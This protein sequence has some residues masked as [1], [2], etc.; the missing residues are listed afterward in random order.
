[1]LHLLTAKTCFPGYV[2][3]PS[4]EFLVRNCRHRPTGRQACS[5]AQFLSL[6]RNIWVSCSRYY[7]KRLPLKWCLLDFWGQRTNWGQVPPGSPCLSAG[8]GLRLPHFAIPDAN[9]FLIKGQY[10]NAYH[11][12]VAQTCEAI[13]RI[14]FRRSPRETSTL[15]INAERWNSHCN[16]QLKRVTFQCPP[17]TYRVDKKVSL[18]IIAITLCAVNQL[19]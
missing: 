12:H 9:K 13:I 6:Q 16:D 19:S 10:T 14:F 4:N 15:F 5:Q 1:V 8:K 11:R 7:T 17:S 18:I 2:E 3:I